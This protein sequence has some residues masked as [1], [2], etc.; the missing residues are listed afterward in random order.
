[1][2]STL[3]FESSDPSSNLGRTCFL[4]TADFCQGHLYVHFLGICLDCKLTQTELLQN[5]MMHFSQQSPGEIWHD[6][7]TG[8]CSLKHASAGNRTRAARVAG[9]HSTTEPPMLRKNEVHWKVFSKVVHQAPYR[10]FKSFICH[11]STVT[12]TSI[13]LKQQGLVRD[14]NPGPLAP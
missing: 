7:I 9:E 1:M 6:P 11:D 14:L 2:V 3:D 13:V 8:N 4:H 5:P 12:G 10:Y